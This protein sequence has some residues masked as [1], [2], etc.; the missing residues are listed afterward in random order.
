MIR[1]NILIIILIIFPL[2][3]FALEKDLDSGVKTL[4]DNL[5]NSLHLIDSKNYPLKLAMIPLTWD[6]E[7]QW[8]LCK[9]VFELLKSQ[10]A[11]KGGVYIIS[12]DEVI[13]AI[14]NKKVNL[15]KGL[16]ET[17]EILD[18]RKTLDCDAVLSGA[19]TDLYVAININLYLWNATDGNLVSLESVQIR[20]TADIVSLLKPL[21][22]EQSIHQSYYSL[23]WRSEVLPYRILSM[24]IDDI[25]NDGINET[26]I[27]TGSDIKVL[28]WDGFSFWE[29][30]SIQYIDST[31]LRR[32]QAN[33]RT[34][35]RIDV[36]KISISVPDFDAEIWRL[37]GDSFVRVDSLAEN[38]LYC[39]DEK[40]IFST[41][42]QDRN[43][44]SGQSTYK[45]LKTDN[46]RIDIKLP[47]DYYSISI[48]D[49]AST[50]G[51]EYVII[52]IENRLR[53]YSKDLELIWQSEKMSFGVGIAIADIDENGV[54][55]II[56]TSALPIGSKDYLIVMEQS[57]DTYVKK[58]ESPIINGGIT[59]ICIGDPDYDS[60]KEILAAISTN[61][62]S[63]IRIY[64]VNYIH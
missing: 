44:F 57:G 53:I 1:L 34:I 40:F 19:I 11:R 43:F 13:K 59:N 32:N 18:L 27:V 33:I 36:D 5:Y 51:E 2:Q 3:T 38:L 60:A 41:I 15:T 47:V 45:I 58:W 25:N 37:N 48:G 9:V 62:G 14:A 6:K 16:I 35:C 10:I 39:D 55:E 31:K 50:E 23:K 4:A 7:D 54:K 52:D 42:K 17:N 28:Y 63:E 46:S 12:G 22:E 29:K 20:K 26:L 21:S 64:S 61:N 30:S 24:L 56:L 8:A 49:V